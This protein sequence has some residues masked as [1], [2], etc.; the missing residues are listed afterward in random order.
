M[1]K[2]PHARCKPCWNSF[3]AVHKYIMSIH[4]SIVQQIAPLWASW[5]CGAGSGSV[6][7]AAPECLPGAAILLQLCDTGKTDRIDRFHRR[8]SG[9][10][11]LASLRGQDEYASSWFSIPWWNYNVLNGTAWGRGEYACML[12]QHAV[13]ASWRAQQNCPRKVGRTFF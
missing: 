13:M 5:C 2:C 12:I 11:T 3:P 1:Q 6:Y 7:V 9:S 4:T 10:P 8:R